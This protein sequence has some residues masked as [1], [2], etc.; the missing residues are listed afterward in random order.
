[1]KKILPLFAILLIVAACGSDKH[2]PGPVVNVTPKVD[3][4]ISR[5]VIDGKNCLYYESVIGG[6]SGKIVAFD[7]DWSNTSGR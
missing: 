1:M 5:V 3:G 7:C 6:H 2:I 4:T